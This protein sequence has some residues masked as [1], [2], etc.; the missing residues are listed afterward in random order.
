MAKESEVRKYLSS[1]G[2]ESLGVYVCN[3]TTYIA[4]HCDS[5]ETRKNAEEVLKF[6]LV[7]G[8]IIL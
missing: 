5:E 4:I 1:M 3:G 6:Y 8:E 2:V 7:D